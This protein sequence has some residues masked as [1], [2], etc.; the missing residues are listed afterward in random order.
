LEIYVIYLKI[1]FNFF[2]ISQEGIY[3]KMIRTSF[4]KVKDYWLKLSSCVEQHYH[5]KTLNELLYMHVF[6][7]LRSNH[8]R[9]MNRKYHYSFL[10][11]QFYQL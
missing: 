7:Q 3:D 10:L 1:I 5:M 2:K 4:R 11:Q 9:N 6:L 8:Y